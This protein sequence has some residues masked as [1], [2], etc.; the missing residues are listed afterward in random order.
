[1]NNSDDFMGNLAM[2]AQ[3]LNS[4]THGCGQ[5]VNTP[6]L[7]NYS[8]GIDL[9]GIIDETTQVVENVPHMKIVTNTKGNLVKPKLKNNITHDILRETDRLLA[10]EKDPHSEFK[11]DLKELAKIEEMI[12]EYNIIIKKLR[13]KKNDLREKT[14]VH[15]VKHEVDGAKVD[16]VSKPK[17][18][19]YNMVE[20]KKK[21]NPMTQKIL[22][23]KLRDFFVKEERMTQQE[24]EIKANRI[25]KW[26]K[27]NAEYV[28]K[29]VLQKKTKE[30]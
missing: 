18:Y 28:M 25:I 6:T 27:D 15:M 24:A 20:V 13:E 19:T 22:P 29:K 16:S 5:M 21:V 1:M 3:Q 7:E 12:E 2:L 17:S 11:I 10:L 9:S 26:I 30:Q 8:S 4:I 23:L 14:I